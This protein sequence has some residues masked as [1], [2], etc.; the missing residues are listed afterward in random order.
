ME[1][2]QLETFLAVAEERSF[3][4]AASRLHRT[5]PAV[6]QVIRKLEE[7]L[8]EVLFDRAARDGSLT[9]AGTLLHD[10]AL[11]LM[12][13]RREATSAL[14]EL[15][16]LERGRLHMAANE[17]TCTYLLPA[18][19][20]FRREYPQVTVTVQRMLASHIPDE[21][22]LRTF[23][24]GVISFRPDPEQF[25]TIAVYGDSLALIVSPQHHL[26]GAGRV[27][28]ADLGN[29]SFIAHNVASPLRRKVIEA[30]QRYRTPLNM[31][32]ELPTIEAI[33]RFVSMGNGVA[34]IPHLTVAREL[35]T[36]E[37]VAVAVAELEMKRVLRLVHRRHGTLSYAA[38]AFLRTVRALARRTGP[39]F[40]YHV[41]KSA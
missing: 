39:P 33:K 4:R 23:E 24:M 13:L 32:I 38:T 25:R 22:N 15:K 9:A 1:L 12:A 8:G 5:Q 14:G 17:Y 28:I 36:G 29:E 26:A 7:S 16:S 18:I 37:L 20:E 30:F 40:Y 27:S 3:S 10:Y 19:D 2:N 11:R 34:L 31:D 35:E 41:E 21:L 6:S